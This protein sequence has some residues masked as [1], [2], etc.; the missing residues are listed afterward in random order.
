MQA[1]NKWVLSVLLALIIII[2]AAVSYSVLHRPN[3]QIAGVVIPKPTI[4]HKHYLLYDFLALGSFTFYYPANESTTL[5]LHFSNEQGYM[6]TKSV[7]FTYSIDDQAKVI[8]FSLPP[9]A[10][11]RYSI[12]LLAG[13]VL[14]GNLSV[15]GGMINDIF[16][17]L[18]T[19]TYTQSISYSFTLVNSGYSSGF[20]VVELR[21]DGV[22]VWS[23]NYYLEAG[24]SEVETGTATIPDKEDHGFSLM[25]VEQE[26]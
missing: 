17:S 16:F 6:V 18:T 25:V 21:S 20:A 4:S 15:S 12:D 10:S 8:S 7:A 5:N 19:T 2:A 24:G 1:M 11:T 23:N 26:R 9:Y 3:I 13:Q 22:S 14:H